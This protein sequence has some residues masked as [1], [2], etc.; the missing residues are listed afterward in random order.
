MEGILHSGPPGGIYA[1][2]VILQQ[3]SNIRVITLIMGK[4]LREGK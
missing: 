2:L 1:P 3:P 4:K